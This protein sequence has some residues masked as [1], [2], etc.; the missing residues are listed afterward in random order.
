MQK[1]KDNVSAEHDGL[2]HGSAAVP[3]ANAE[4]DVSNGMHADR[5]KTNGDGTVLMSPENRAWLDE[6][7][8]ENKD[9]LR[10]LSE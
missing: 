6:F 7:I 10:L 1:T 9:V 3:Q 2:A 4:H 8:S 5:P